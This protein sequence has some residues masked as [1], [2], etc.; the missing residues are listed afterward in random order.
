MPTAV[1][2]AAATLLIDGL[3]IL[4]QTGIGLMLVAMFAFSLNDVMGKWLVATYGVAQ[5]LL[6]RSFAGLLM[7]A[8]AIQRVGLKTIL[9]PD[10]I[11]LHILRAI[12]STAEVALFYW[13]VVY[14]PLAEVAEFFSFG[15]N[16][17]TQFL[18]AADRAD[19]RLAE[20]YDWLSPAILRFIRRIVIACEEHKVDLTVCG[21]MGG[22]TLEAMALV[23]I[24]LRRLS[25]TPAAVGA[26]KA[27]VRSLDSEAIAVEMETI[28]SS[29]SGNIRDRLNQWATSQGVEIA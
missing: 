26:I 21:E 28:L 24:G 7:L 10:R 22:R 6:I 4:M 20:R 5:L 16:D 25:I 9:T 3:G 11:D 15:T 23:G 27:M 13:A 14:L 18:F 8:P 1:Q 29:P 17:L 19:P 12:C 2:K